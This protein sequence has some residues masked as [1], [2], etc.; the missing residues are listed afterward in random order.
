VRQAV[1]GVVELRGIG[2][3]GTGWIVAPNIIATA[4]HV[5]TDADAQHHMIVTD[6]AGNNYLGTVIARD[7]GHDAAL[8]R[9]ANFDEPTRLGEFRVPDRTP[10]KLDDVTQSGEQ[11]AV[12]GYP[13]GQFDV[14]WAQLTGLATVGIDG[15]TSFEAISMSGVADHGNSGGPV[16]NANGEV[17]G[18]IV[19]L[20]GDRLIAVENDDIKRLLSHVDVDG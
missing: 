19:A 2:H 20:Y 17:I 4:N 9:V 7:P 10:L 1:D 5:A 13:Q 18:M 6:Q 12:I 3:L 16:V 15:H 14:T 8:V 11:G